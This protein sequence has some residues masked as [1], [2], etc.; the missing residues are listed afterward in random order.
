MLAV[1]PLAPPKSRQRQFAHRPN[2]RKRPFS[3]DQDSMAVWGSLPL[4]LILQYS[5][6]TRSSSSSSWPSRPCHASRPDMGTKQCTSLQQLCFQAGLQG[7]RVSAMR[8][9][10]KR[11][12]E[13]AASS[14]RRTSA[15]S[16]ASTRMTMP[17]RVFIYSQAT[18]SRMSRSSK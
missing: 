8:Q 10:Y 11:W 4:V 9:Q 16:R 5:L 13:G 17:R 1:A 18:N 12:R 6:P 2:R 15:S 7:R 14:S 3:S